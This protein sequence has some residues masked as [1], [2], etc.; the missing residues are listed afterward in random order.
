MVAVQIA[1][2]VQNLVQNSSVACYRKQQ[3]A[4]TNQ[5]AF[6]SISALQHFS[7]FMMLV[8]ALPWVMSKRVYC[9]DETE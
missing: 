9:E 8:L 3:V 4:N 1:G 2:L 7:Y 6:Y 5:I